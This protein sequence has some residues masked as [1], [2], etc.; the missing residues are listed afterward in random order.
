[1][2]INNQY[3]TYQEY[4]SLGGD[5]IGEMPFNLLEFEARQNVDKYTL[6]RLKELASQ[7]DEVKL[8]IY[9]LVGIIK[10]YQSL[11]EQNKA[12]ASESIDGYSVTYGNG[13]N[14]ANT[15]SAKSNDLKEIIR[16][17]L[18]DCKLDDGTPYLYRGV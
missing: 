8:C 3:L 6:G 11:E 1:M 12:L 10:S 5:N 18:I 9:K 14:G 13:G 15:E 4:L 17:Y 2:T 7:V 16:T